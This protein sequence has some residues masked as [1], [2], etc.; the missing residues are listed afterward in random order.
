MINLRIYLWEGWRRARG[1]KGQPA[2]QQLQLP[3]REDD[4]ASDPAAAGLCWKEGEKEGGGRLME[5][6]AQSAQPAHGEKEDYILCAL[7]LPVRS[8]SLS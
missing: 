8:R 7:V 6:P 4:S 2:L 5:P 1:Q 3:S